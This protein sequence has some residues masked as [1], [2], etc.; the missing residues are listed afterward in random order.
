MKSNWIIKRTL[1]FFAVY[2]LLLIFVELT[3]LKKPIQR[4]V[5]SVSAALYSDFKNGGQVKFE[6]ISKREDKSLFK[7][8]DVLIT[9]T[10]KQQKDRIRKQAIK[11][12]KKTAT[13]HPIKFAVNSWLSLGMFFPFFISLL[14]V[15][16]ASLKNKAFLLVSG[17]IFIELFF[18]FKL[19]I[20]LSNQFGKYFSK[21]EVGSSSDFFLYGLN[22]LFNI[23]NFPY[24]GF[25]LISLFCLF[26]IDKTKM[27]I[28]KK[29][30]D[31]YPTNELSIA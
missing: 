6:D 18:C 10:S 27:K 28:T 30:T 31:S 22:H 7:K 14:I 5:K 19:W 4:H 17:V 8:D 2:S 20:A 3:G 23:I 11:E 26:F 15:L 9:L 21:F 16:P 1:L 25:L 29:Q 12:K 13:I 24:F